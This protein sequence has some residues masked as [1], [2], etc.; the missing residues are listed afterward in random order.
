MFRALPPA[1]VPISAGDLLAGLV[2]A[3]RGDAALA[4][5]RED[6]RRTFGVRH[7]FLASS[8]RAA[9][10]ILLQGLRALHPDRDVVAL[11]AYTSFSVPSAVVHAG[12][13]ISLYDVD[14][15]TL[16][17][18]QESLARVVD[19]R[20]LAVVVCHLYGYPADIDSVRQITGPHGVPVIDDAAQAMGADF[21]GKPAGTCGEAGLFSLSRGKNINA[22]DGGIIVTNCEE[23]AGAIEQVMF[24]DTAEGIPGLFFKALILSLLLRPTLYWLPRSLP[25]LNIGASVFDPVLPVA[26]FTPFQAGLARRMLARLPAITA[27]R[28]DVAGWLGTRLG[29]LR[30]LILPRPVTGAEA[31]YLRFPVIVAEGESVTEAPELG[32]V[33]SYPASLD[34]LPG[35]QAHSNRGGGPYPGAQLLAG[36]V[37]TV[38]THQFVTDRDRRRII[39]HFSTR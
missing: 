25:F 27:G 14:P 7:V 33:R 22:V 24:T 39:D 3:R 19:K 9:L 38:P 18:V 1:G 16:S 13:R 11:P 37:L 17:P 29:E 30:T 35:L 2:A 10:S 8:G 15:V 6:I 36:Q 12:V 21:R 20:T 28:R 23:L 26:P 32:I 34:A 5:F 31:V 4:D